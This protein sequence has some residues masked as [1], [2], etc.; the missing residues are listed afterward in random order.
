MSNNTT[1]AARYA[2]CG[3]VIERPTGS[4]TV[5][6]VSKEGNESLLNIQ[7]GNESL[8]KKSIFV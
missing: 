4:L 3:C 1:Y 5:Y 2:S 8:S 7:Q 6:K